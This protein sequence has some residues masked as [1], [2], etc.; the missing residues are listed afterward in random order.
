MNNLQTKRLAANVSKRQSLTKSRT[1]L[2]Q[3][4]APAKLPF[5]GYTE[6]IRMQDAGSV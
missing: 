6:D 3:G 5:Q 2:S 4:T 1:A